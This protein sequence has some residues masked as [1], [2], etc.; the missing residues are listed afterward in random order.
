M[1]YVFGDR[2]IFAMSHFTF[3]GIILCMP[4]SG[5]LASGEQ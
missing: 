2:I 1:Y 4:L 3:H 5:F